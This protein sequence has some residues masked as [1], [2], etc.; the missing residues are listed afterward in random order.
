MFRRKIE[1]YL[2]NW[3]KNR[4]TALIVKGARQVGKTYFI[5]KFINENFESVIEVNFVN[6]PEY[7]DTFASFKNSEE[8]LI[9]LSA[10]VGEKMIKNKTVVFF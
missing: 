1:I 8:L 4:K 10:I 6:N 9:R 7:I 3:L 5:S 2:Q